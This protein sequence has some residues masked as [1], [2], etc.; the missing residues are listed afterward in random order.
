MPELLEPLSCEKSDRRRAPWRQRLV[1]TERGLT[2]G[3]RSDGSLYFYVFVDCAV[4]LVG[5]VL[6]LNLWQWFIV[7]LAVTM[8]ITAELF[9][10]ALR[11][12][13]A[14]LR[15]LQP[16]GHWDRALHLATA[17]VSVAFA[18]GSVVVALVYWQRIRELFSS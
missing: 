12:C 6:D 9:Q 8:V 7:G 18:G 13:I 14:E 17:A 10:Q 5:G 15:E 4:L 16:A 2:R 11:T 1:E 3:F